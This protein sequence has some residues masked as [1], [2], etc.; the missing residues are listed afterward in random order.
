[1]LYSV[2]ASYLWQENAFTYY[3]NQ[4]FDIVFALA[5]K[6]IFTQWDKNR[7]HK[8]GII[9]WV[10]PKLLSYSVSACKTM[11]I[12]WF[13]IYNKFIFQWVI[14]IIQK[15]KNLVFTLYNDKC[16]NVK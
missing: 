7:V 10:L 1:M 6:S 16:V 3:R 9:L 5:L 14:S 4:N 15:S 12:K 13:C 11:V 2:A 8:M